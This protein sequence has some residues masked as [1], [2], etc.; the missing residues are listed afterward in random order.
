MHIV[1]E[2]LKYFRKIKKLTQDEIANKLGIS[3]SC[4]ANYEQGIRQP[5][6]DIFR[7][8]CIILECT[9][10]EILGLDE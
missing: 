2:N 9:S 5:S 10:D 7:N 8:I 4:Y 3:R 6:I 1:K